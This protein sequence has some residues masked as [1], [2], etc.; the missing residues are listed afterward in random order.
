MAAPV[1]LICSVC[2]NLADTEMQ[3][4]VGADGK[5]IEWP[6]VETKDRQLCFTIDCPNCGARRQCITAPDAK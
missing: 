6:K 1:Q 3:A 5:R 4:Y 2:G